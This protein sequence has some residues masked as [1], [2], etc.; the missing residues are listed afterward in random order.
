MPES[1]PRAAQSPTSEAVTNFGLAVAITALAASLCLGG[2]AVRPI[3]P[4][5]AHYVPSGGYRWSPRRD[6][7]DN[8]PRTLLILTFSGGG[9]RAAAFAY[10]VL[11]ELRRTPV[12]GANGTTT[13]ALSQIDLVTGTSG[14]SFTALAYALYGEKLFDFYDRTFL[15]RDIEGEL[16][17]RLFN[18]FRWPQVLSQGFGRS[19]LAEEYY[20]EILFHDATYGDLLRKQTPVALVGATDVTTGSRLDF[21]QSTFDV[22]CGDLSRFPLSRAAAASSAVPIVLSPV[23]LDNRGGSCG[24]HPPVWMAG[25]MELSEGRLTGNRAELR[26]RQLARLEDSRARPYIHLVDGGLSDNLGLYGIVQA[27]QE[28]MANPEFRAAMITRGLRRVVVVVVN[29]RSA[30]SFGFDKDPDGP[31]TF[32]L[33]MQSI[34]VPIDRFSTEAIAALHDIIAQWRLNERLDADERRL[35]EKIGPGGDIPPVEFSVIDVSF[36]AVADPKLRE[37]L[38]NLPTSFALSD[39]AV[40]KLRA[41]AAQLLHESPAFQKLVDELSRENLR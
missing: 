20:D 19:E 37:Y 24:Y 7:P 4:E 39:E 33:L 9:T 1:T 30:P 14:G 38:Q 11:E 10:G 6:L 13:P 29:A 8:D 16:L 36:E 34:S 32:A 17:Q 41:T 40:D 22:M 25:A 15:K 26:F 3:T 21:S 2:C 35:G 18:P 31:G 5:L 12:Q 23:T 27:L 28:I